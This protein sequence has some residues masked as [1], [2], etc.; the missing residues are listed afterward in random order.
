MKKNLLVLVTV[1]VLIWLFFPFA[2]VKSQPMMGYSSIPDSDADYL[3]SLRISKGEGLY[4]SFSILYPPGRFF[5]QA[6]LFKIFTPSVALSFTSHISA[7]FVFFPAALFVLSFYFFELIFSQFRIK[8]YSSL[9]SYVL[10][11]A[12]ILIYLDFFR[13]AQE[14]HVLSALFFIIVLTAKKLTKVRLLSLG[15]LLGLIFLFRL[16]SGILLLDALFFLLIPLI[17]FKETPQKLPFL[18]GFG[19]VWVPTI[20][21][22]MINGSLYNFLYDTL[23]LGLI[24]QPKFMSLPI[25][26]NELRFVWL[27]TL[28]FV[29]T[30]A[31]GIMVESKK[32]PH[33]VQRLGLQIFAVFVVVSYVTALGR[34]DEPHLWYGLTWFP[35]LLLYTVVRVGI[36]I[37]RRE[38][39]SIKTCVFIAIGFYTY[40]HVVLQLKSPAFFLISVPI[41]FLIIRR[42]TRSVFSVLIAGTITALIVFHSVSYLK[43]LFVRQTLPTTKG[44]QYSFVTSEGTE[45][46]GM[47][48]GTGSDEQVLQQIRADIP[49]EEKYLFIFPKNVILNEY[50]HL[51]NP[52]RYII[53]MNERSDWT[54]QQVI[55]QLNQTRTKYFLIFPE[56]ALLRKAQVWDWILANTTVIHEYQ[57]SGEKAELRIRE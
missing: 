2:L 29:M 35:V 39:I 43:L 33:L 19:L 18:S 42:Y 5:L 51:T 22:I 45:V 44:F 3:V 34:S 48:M 9:I 28:L 41:I 27:A 13:S 4:S 24:I 16:D 23:I 32:M 38:R 8:K 15:V 53:L 20:I 10:S 56:P 37:L 49:A 14:V 6:L 17:F 11:I 47:L 25:P 7:T 31:A 52:T 57:F 50:F 30:A 21:A 55:D 26:F 1:L 36:G 40:G 46:G 12:A 54:E